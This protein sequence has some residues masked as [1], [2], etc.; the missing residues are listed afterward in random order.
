MSFD[1]NLRWLDD[2]LGQLPNS[3]FTWVSNVDWAGYRG[4]FMSRACIDQSSTKQKERV[5]LPSPKIV[6]GSP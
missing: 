2:Q 6:M 1:L 4:V 3:E 5:W